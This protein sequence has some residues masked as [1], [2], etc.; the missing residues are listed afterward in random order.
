MKKKIDEDGEE[1]HINST[2]LQSE[3][4]VCAL[5][6]NCKILSFHLEKSYRPEQ[7]INSLS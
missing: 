3:N 5:Q 1:K 4:A 7:V 6:I 2:A